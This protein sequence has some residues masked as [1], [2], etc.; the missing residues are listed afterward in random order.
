MQDALFVIRDLNRID[1]DIAAARK[2]LAD[3]IAAVRSTTALVAAENETLAKTGEALAKALDEERKLSRRMEEYVIRRDRT[4]K[5]IDE[6]KAPDFQS[7]NRQL[8][9]C[10]AIVDDL[11][12]EVLE[13]MELREELEAEVATITER[14]AATRAKDSSGR[15]AYRDAS[16]GL[17]KTV[18]ELTARRPPFL[19]RL[20]P[21]ERRIYTNLHDAGNAA[22]THIEHGVCQDCNR[23]VPQQAL[24]EVESGK[25]IHRCRGCG[26]FF[27]SVI[28]PE[29]EE[30]G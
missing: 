30:S 8:Q 7:A 29:S 16:P 17:K 27:F 3:M 14:L 19:E 2:M 1:S 11:E 28:H 20:N 21:D 10:A 25:R 23:E 9:Q 26:R 6:G 5:L 12:L 4:Q 15:S 22:M 18:T 13:A 24:L